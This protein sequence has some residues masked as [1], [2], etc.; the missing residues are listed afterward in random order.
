MIIVIDFLD[1]NT[2]GDLAHAI[3]TRDCGNV[4]FAGLD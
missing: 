4:V 3:G 1:F 2:S